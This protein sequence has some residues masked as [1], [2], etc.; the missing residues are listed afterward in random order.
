M[1]VC[2]ICLL[3][4]IVAFKWCSTFCS[5]KESVNHITELGI[6]SK[7]FTPTNTHKE[8]FN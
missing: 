6:A 5:E 8:K 1:N 3:A 7:H 2:N 4:L